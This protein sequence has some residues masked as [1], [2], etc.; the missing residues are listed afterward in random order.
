[1]HHF[2]VQRHKNLNNFTAS[3]NGP[4]PVTVK[5]QFAKILR[6]TMKSARSDSSSDSNKPSLGVPDKSHSRN[7]KYR[8]NLVGQS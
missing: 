4:F 7:D 6:N 1:M 5:P 8:G 3:Q 2:R